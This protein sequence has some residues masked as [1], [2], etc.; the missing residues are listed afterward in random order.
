[1]SER[2]QRAQARMFRKQELETTKELRDV[3]TPLC[4]GV[5]EVVMS[6]GI[7]EL[8]E[9]GERIEKKPLVAP[10]NQELWDSNDHRSAI[11]HLGETRDERCAAMVVGRLRQLQFAMQSNRSW[12][13][14][15]VDERTRKKLIETMHGD[16]WPVLLRGEHDRMLEIGVDAYVEEA[17]GKNGIFPDHTDLHQDLERDLVW[18]DEN[19]Q[20]M[21]HET[22]ILEYTDTLGGDDLRAFCGL[23]VFIIDNYRVQKNTVDSLSEPVDN[24]YVWNANESDMGE[25]GVPAYVAFPVGAY[26]EK[27][28][29]DLF[30]ATQVLLKLSEE[31]GGM[32]EE[33]ELEHEKL[34]SGTTARARHR[35]PDGNFWPGSPGPMLSL[36]EG[37]VTFAQTLSQLTAERIEGYDDPYE[38]LEDI[39]KEE[40]PTKVGL[41]IP[42]GEMGPI[43]VGAR[44]IPGLIQRKDDGKPGL[45]R[46]VVKGF[47]QRRK[48]IMDKL[49]KQ[50]RRGYG[51]LGHGCPV[52]RTGGGF[53]KSG[54]T[55]LG[56]AFLRVFKAITESKKK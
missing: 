13:G 45:S 30:Q 44:K 47:V 51:T 54:N 31:L 23:Q 55:M 16:K 10:R 32:A 53:E 9:M 35:G 34:L 49:H 46:D 8:R 48:K 37:I 21:D 7:E 40:L 12:H 20:N 27:F 17:T 39:I 4:E 5:R 28:A 33:I 2:L 26:G 36:Q 1:M 3:F 52:S 19:I 15:P 42:Q 25:G 29:K 56:E 11:S 14:K 6:R 50:G 43:A 38:L 41:F 22:N 24:G 18:I